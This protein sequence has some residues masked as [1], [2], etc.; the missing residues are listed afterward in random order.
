TGKVVKSITAT[1]TEAP[2]LFKRNGVY[3]LVYS[4]PNCG[5]CSGTGASYRT[6]KWP[7][8]PWSDGTKISD[9]SCGGQPSFVSSIKLKTGEVF[10]FGS[11]LWNNGAKN[12]SLANYYW[13]PLTFAPDGSINRISCQNT[14]TSIPARTN[15]TKGAGAIDELTA[16]GDINSGHQQTQTFKPGERGVLASLIISCFKS[17]YPNDDLIIEV[18]K[19]GS[20]NTLSSIRVPSDSVSWSPK[21]IVIHP[22]IPIQAESI[23]S[24]RISSNSTKGTY[25]L[26]YYPAKQGITGRPFLFQTMI[27]S[28]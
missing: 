11:D 9:S 25:G 15:K 27:I 22:D 10:L 3:Y 4:D 7:L 28:K 5:Y 13:A 20:V 2:A 23:Y 21:N 8:G 1:R 19:V 12:E 24:I 26:E 18:S 16:I 6:A 17:A 14:I